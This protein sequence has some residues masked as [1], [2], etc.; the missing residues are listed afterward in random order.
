[1]GWVMKRNALYM[2]ESF[3]KMVFFVC[4]L[5]VGEILFGG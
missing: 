5:E 4:D 1:M 2:R 3:K